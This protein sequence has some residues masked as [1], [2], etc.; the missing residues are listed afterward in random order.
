MP[1]FSKGYPALRRGRW[2]MEHADYFLTICARRP[3]DCLHVEPLL[4]VGLREF[5]RLSADGIWVPRCAVFMPDHPH[6]LVTLLPSADLSSAVRSFKGRMTP[7]LRKAPAN[8]QNSFYDH[9]LRTS[10]DLLPVFLYI[11]LNPY[12]ANFCAPDQ[13]WPGYWCA[14]EDWAWFGVMTRESCPEPEWLR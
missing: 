4:E 10:D 7:A 1:R 11:Y 9:R 6:L 5:H 2:S 12:R 13:T 8:W 14:P 3:A